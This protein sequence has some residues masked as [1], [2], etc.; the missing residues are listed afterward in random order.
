M[1]L[2]VSSLIDS[3]TRNSPQEIEY[4]FGWNASDLQRFVEDTNRQ[5]DAVKRAGGEK[6]SV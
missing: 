1:T 3:L 2:I 4:F 5:A 6:P